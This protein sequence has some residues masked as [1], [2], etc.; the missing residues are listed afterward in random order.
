MMKH[1]DIAR[2]SIRFKTRSVSIPLKSTLA[3]GVR[4]KSKSNM[5]L[6]KTK[7]VDLNKIRNRKIRH[8]I[9]KRTHTR[10]DNIK[11]SNR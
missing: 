8:N 7:S 6:P 9:M 2:T 1:S 10:S 5:M 4:N 11:L 3:Y